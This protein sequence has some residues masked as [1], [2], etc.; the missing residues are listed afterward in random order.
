M[1][2]FPA[3]GVRRRG[4]FRV[5][6]R[7][8]HDSTI[9]E[10]AGRLDLCSSCTLRESLI[11]AVDSGAAK[12]LIDL[13]GVEFIDSTGLSVLAVVARHPRH[14]VTDLAIVCPEGRVREALRAAGLDQVI[15]V[16]STKDAALAE[17]AV[18]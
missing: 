18:A 16:R 13:S 7:T 12:V 10:V 8:V 1:R 3:G 15:P 5:S 2:L 9:V 6:R 17:E 4:E 11:S 14:G